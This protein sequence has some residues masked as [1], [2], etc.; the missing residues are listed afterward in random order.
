MKPQTVKE[1]LVQA[2]LASIAAPDDQV[3]VEWI[4]H[5]ELLA[6]ELPRCEVADA[7][8]TVNRLLR[9]VASSHTP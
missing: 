5:A 7:R 1:E 9:E 3:S 4:A 6:A 8:R 2:M